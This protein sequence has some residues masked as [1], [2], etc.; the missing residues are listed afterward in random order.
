MNKATVW[1]LLACFL[2]SGPVL[3]ADVP[4]KTGQGGLKPLDPKAWDYGKARHLLFRA[5]FGGPASA[6]AKLEAQGLEKAVSSLLDVRAMPAFELAAEVKW[7]EPLKPGD[8]AKLSSDERMKLFIKRMLE[9][10]MANEQVKEWWLKR[11][12]ESPRQLEEKMTLFWHGH[13]ATEHRT[14]RNAQSMLIQ[15]QLFREHA[16]GNYGKL[17]HAIIRDPAML[18][19]L[20]NDR[21]IKGKPNENLAREIMEL[22]SMGEG[23][24]YTEKDVKE[25]ARALTGYTFDRATLKPRF[26]AFNHDRGSKTIFGKTG[27]FNGDEFVDL[28][29][30]QPATPRFLAR[31]LFVFFVHDQPSAQTIDQLAQL[32][33]THNYELTPVLKTLFLSEE[34]YSAKTLGTQIKSP[35]QLVVGTLRTLEQRP[36]RL[37]F[38][39]Q[40]L[41][42]MGQDLLNPPNVK[43]WDGGQA[44]INT[45]TLFLRE[46]FASGVV[47]GGPRPGGF[48]PKGERKLPFAFG[49][50]PLDVVSLMPDKKGQSPEEV[51]NFW[52]KTLFALPL[53]ETRRAELIGFLGPLPPAADWANRRTEINTKLRGLLSL[54]MSMTEYQLI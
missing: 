20:D 52:A 37:A 30:A 26:A 34:F 5:G 51:V 6:V 38:V 11:M 53:T 22:F 32:I 36:A 16:T 1:P 17:L 47:S 7:A 41:R 54:M 43:G 44:W 40:G 24:G 25:A 18:R 49:G 14:V 15:N 39:A 46:N 27:T 2:L 3:G 4:A 35:V 12:I 13:F 21:N 31:K 23:Q 9:D 19:Y 48:Q 45:N 28:I 42:G 8:F 29:L 33:R 50:S 10:R